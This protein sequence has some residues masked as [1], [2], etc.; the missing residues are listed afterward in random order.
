MEGAF[1]SVYCIGRSELIAW[2]NET[3]GESYSK[4][5][6]CANGVIHCAILSACHP[7]CIPASKVKP[8]AKLEYE[9]VHNFKLLQ[10]GLDKAGVVKHVEVERLVKAKYQDNLEF[11]QVCTVCCPELFALN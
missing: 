4:V 10:A 7:G 6:Q 11:L 5:E 9:C 3:F 2:V 8:D 1:S